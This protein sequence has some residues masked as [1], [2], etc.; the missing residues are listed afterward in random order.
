M[1]IGV[2]FLI[3]SGLNL[4]LSEVNT[5]VPGGAS[6]YDLIHRIKHGQPSGIF[7]RINSLSRKNFRKDFYDYINSLPGIEDLRALK[8]WMD[9][10]GQLP[11]NPAPALRLEDKWIQY[12]LL[13]DEYPLIPTKLFN[14]ENLTDFKNFF[15]QGNPVALKKRLGR[16]GQGFLHIQDS[17]ELSI[18]DLEDNIYLVQPYVKSQIGIYKLSLRAAAFVGEFLCMFANLSPR[19][20]SNHG[21]RFDVSPGDNLKVSEDSFKTRRTVQKAWE[22]DIF[23]K[24]DIP[25]YLYDN[26]YIED[27]AEA[28]LIIP[29]AIFETVKRTAASISR[30]YM[31]LDLNS[32]PKSYIEE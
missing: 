6:E 29:Y 23:Y 14:R 20:T 26:V 16:G 24:G 4:Y 10:K 17:N 9:G 30:L 5:G 15:E 12:L 27:I 22:A 19:L 18:L 32:L 2:D 25:D 28:E 7:D 31:G 3:D 13:S 1:Y 8:I 11:K 21:F